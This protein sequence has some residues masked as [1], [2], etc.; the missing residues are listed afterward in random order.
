[1]RSFSKMELFEEWQRHNQEE[2]N[3]RLMDFILQRF[4]VTDV[5]DVTRDSERSL[6][7]KISCMASKFAKKWS[8]AHMMMDR[9]LNK[10]KIW[11]EGANVEFKV[12]I[13][14][15]C[16]FSS[17]GE[18]QG[19]PKKNFEDLSFKTKK[20]RVKNLVKSQSATKLTTAAEV[21]CRALGH[22]N[23]ATLIRKSLESSE[24]IKSK[25]FIVGAGS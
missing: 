19:R 2:R 7:L 18:I 11:L 6:Q 15:Q 10:N 5:T 24:K 23:Q 17:Y 4:C 13:C 1:M 25:D 14:R 22:R 3:S 21:A 8:A 12:S 9:F 16:T 20:R